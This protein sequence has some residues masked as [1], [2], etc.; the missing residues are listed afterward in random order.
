VW[1]GLSCGTAVYAILLVWRF[2][3]LV[4]TLEFA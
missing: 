2:R 1:I 4:R 3:R